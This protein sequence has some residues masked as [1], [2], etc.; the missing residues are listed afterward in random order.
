RHPAEQCR[1]LGA[2]L[3]EPEDVVDEQ[4]HVLAL[5]VAEVLG[6]RQ[7]R[8]RDSH[9]GAGRLVHLTEDQRGVLEHVGLAELYPQVVALTGALADAGEYRSTT[10]VSG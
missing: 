2:G 6:H 4:Q 3:S 10:E 1:N 7:R 5:L 8:Q 9:T